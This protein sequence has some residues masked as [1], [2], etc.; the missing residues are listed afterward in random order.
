M[1]S[2]RGIGARLERALLASAAHAGCAITIAAIDGVPWSSATFTGARHLVAIEGPAGP[3]MLGWIAALPEADLP[4]R[5]HL[6][7]DLR[8][9]AI[10][11]DTART[12]VHVELL[13]VEDC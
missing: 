5:G 2:R 4:V 9:C 6:V 10:D 13:T 7:A 12:R 3:A 1:I 8:V 11:A